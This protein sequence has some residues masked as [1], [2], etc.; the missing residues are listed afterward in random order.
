ML[1]DCLHSTQLIKRDSMP[2]P[3]VEVICGNTSTPNCTFTVGCCQICQI[4]KLAQYSGCKPSNS[5]SN[6]HVHKADLSLPVRWKHGAQAK[7][8]L[9]LG[10][11]NKPTLGRRKR[12]GLFGWTFVW[13]RQRT[14]PK[15][16][17]CRLW[18]VPGTIWLVATCRICHVRV[19]V[20]RLSGRCSAMQES[21]KSDRCLHKLRVP[22]RESV[23]VNRYII[24]W[25]NG[26][27]LH[28]LLRYR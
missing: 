5:I 1:H 20:W 27:R 6:G 9:A 15:W 7:E 28:N 13:G 12:I 16:F 24:C 22:L 18:L 19:R 17:Y 11:S 14:V 4:N 25:W 26:D 8:P 3:H 10:K 2:S 21:I 23:R